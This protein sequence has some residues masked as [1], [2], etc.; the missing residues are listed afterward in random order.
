[1]TFSFKSSRKKPQQLFK[2]GGKL[3]IS[4]QPQWEIQDI[5]VTPRVQKVRI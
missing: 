5:Q 2:G 4:H 1:M 3:E